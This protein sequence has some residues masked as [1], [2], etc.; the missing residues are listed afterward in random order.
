MS[1]DQMLEHFRSELNRE[2]DSRFAQT[3]QGFS[4]EKLY[5]YGAGRGRPSGNPVLSEDTGT[6]ASRSRSSK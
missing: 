2:A 5:P 4:K 3:M 1:I 6:V